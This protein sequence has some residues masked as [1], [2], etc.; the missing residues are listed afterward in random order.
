MISWSDWLFGLGCGV[1]VG[2]FVSWVLACAHMYAADQEVER[3][4]KEYREKGVES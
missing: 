4:L 2:G 1:I 3:S